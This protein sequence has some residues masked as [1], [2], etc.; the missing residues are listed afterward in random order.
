MQDQDDHASDRVHD[1]DRGP[2]D[3]TADLADGRAEAKVASHLR[4]R[5]L[6]IQDRR[7]LRAFELV[8]R[9]LFVAPRHGDLAARDIALPIGCGQTTAEPGLIGRMV[10]ALAVER[11]HR[12]LEIGAG[13]GYATA[14][15]A[16]LADSVLGLERFRSLAIAAQRRL[17]AQAIGNAAVVW[18]DGLAPTSLG[19]GAFDRVIVHGVLNRGPDGLADRLGEEAV[20]VLARQTAGAQAVVR[21]SGHNLSD[22]RF[23]CACRLQPIRPGLASS[24]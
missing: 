6:G 1:A 24:L 20:V 9:A 15:L 13:S 17:D 21:L 23:V 2:G 16:H 12:V 3:G 5:A 19:D 11:A 4:M 22:E 18:A 7:L 14:I 8:P 10:E